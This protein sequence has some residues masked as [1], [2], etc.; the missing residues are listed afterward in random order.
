[1][2]NVSRFAQVATIQ[3]EI[4]A[5]EYSTVRMSRVFKR[6]CLQLG[7]S[8]KLKSINFNDSLKTWTI[9]KICIVDK[10]FLSYEVYSGPEVLQ[11]LPK[12]IE[13][14]LLA[15]VDLSGSFAVEQLAGTNQPE[16]A[17]ATYCVLCL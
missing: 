7:Q 2:K 1:M 3:Q 9:S 4:E 10:I 16:P 15:R 6:I 5:F 12:K 14:P 11:L 17:G 8:K 13:E